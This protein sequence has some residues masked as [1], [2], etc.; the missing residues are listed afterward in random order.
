LW[1]TVLFVDTFIVAGC[2]AKIWQ[3]YLHSATWLESKAAYV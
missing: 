2:A 1:N 3:A